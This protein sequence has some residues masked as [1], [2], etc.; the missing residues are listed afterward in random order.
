MATISLG[1]WLEKMKR[2]YAKIREPLKNRLLRHQTHYQ[3]G[4]N[5]EACDYV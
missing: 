1:I 4:V 3:K 5:F 2:F